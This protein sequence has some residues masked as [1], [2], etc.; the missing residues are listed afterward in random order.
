MERRSGIPR[1]DIERAMNHYGIS[2]EEYQAHP[3]DYPLPTRGTQ[4]AGMGLGALALIV[5]WILYVSRQRGG[6]R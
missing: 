2:A 4:V 3:G 1:S 6:S 5:L